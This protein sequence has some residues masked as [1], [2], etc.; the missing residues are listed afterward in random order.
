[1]AQQLVWAKIIAKAVNGEP[2]VA[3]VS[4]QVSLLT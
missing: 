2:S 4:H 3:I 1:M